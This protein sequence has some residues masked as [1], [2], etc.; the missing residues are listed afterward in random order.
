M[1]QGRYWKTACTH[2][3]VYA[4]VWMWAHRCFAQITAADGNPGVVCMRKRHYTA[5]RSFRSI[6]H[7]Q[8][9]AYSHLQGKRSAAHHR[10]ALEV[11]L[12]DW[13]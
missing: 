9:H 13:R 10:T 3:T 1:P 2:A 6:A 4:Q 8:E 5:V 7:K 11:Q 12:V